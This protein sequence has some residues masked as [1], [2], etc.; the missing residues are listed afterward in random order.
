[1]ARPP[2]T[3]AEMPSF[4]ALPTV[5]V[6]RSR[7]IASFRSGAGIWEIGW[8]GVWVKAWARVATWPTSS[9]LQRPF[10]PDHAPATGL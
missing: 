4:D 1:M 7:P 3:L 2:R 10:D 8:N 5:T 6:L 9:S